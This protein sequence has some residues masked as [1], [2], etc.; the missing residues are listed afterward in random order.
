M[1]GL[2]YKLKTSKMTLKEKKEAVQIG[3]IIKAV[4][5]LQ[6]LLHKSSYYQQEWTEDCEGLLDALINLNHFS[7]LTTREFISKYK[8]D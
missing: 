2:F 8:K 4:Q 7:N 3:K 6:D 5:K 1:V